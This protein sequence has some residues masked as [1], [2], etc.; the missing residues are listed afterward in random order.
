MCAVG[1]QNNR[2]L[3]LCWRWILPGTSLMTPQKQ[4][5]RERINLYT[6]HSHGWSWGWSHHLM[7]GLVNQELSF[8]SQRPPVG[9][10][11][12]MFIKQGEEQECQGRRETSRLA[13]PG[14]GS[15]LRQLG[16]GGRFKSQSKLTFAIHTGINHSIS[17]LK[18]SPFSEFK[19]LWDFFAPKLD[20]RS[21]GRAQLFTGAGRT[22]AC[23][24]V[25]RDVRHESRFS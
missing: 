15:S 18:P 19:W 20:D 7:V 16:G 24:S 5:M 11:E 1:S 2:I 14:R 17:E 4:S 10:L 23:N 3:L 12:T 21:H 9:G 13:A 22:S 25:W 8:L 6:C